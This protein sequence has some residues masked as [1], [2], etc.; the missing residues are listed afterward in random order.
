MSDFETALRLALAR[1]KVDPQD[2]SFSTPLSNYRNTI[3]LALAKDAEQGDERRAEALEHQAN[4][5]FAMAT[6]KLVVA[7]RDPQLSTDTALALWEGALYAVEQWKHILRDLGRPESEFSEPNRL[8]AIVE[9]GVRRLVRPY[10]SVHG[11]TGIDARLRL[12]ELARF[13]PAW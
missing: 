7:A 11:I 5:V 9:D 3:A 13:G 10:E 1:Q 2:V 12:L 6:A 8:A 4:E